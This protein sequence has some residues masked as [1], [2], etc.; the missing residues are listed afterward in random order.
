MK[1]PK[2]FALLYCMLL[3]TASISLAQEHGYV[4]NI[5][6]GIVFID[7]K[8]GQVKTGD[9]LK[10]MRSGG[11][12]VHPVTG[13]T[14]Q[15]RDELVANIHLT[16]V[17]D[18]YSA[19][20]V[21]P[22]EAI[23]LIKTGMKV[24]P[25]A[26]DEA[27]KALIKKSVV[28]PPFLIVGG[29]VGELGAYMSDLMT[30]ELFGLDRF[31]I[32]DRQTYDIQQFEKELLEARTQV[33][34]PV[35]EGVDYL[36]T[37]SAYPPDVV[38]KATG[39]PLKGIVSAAGG[40]LAGVAA[41]NLVPDLK[42]KELEAVVK[43]TLKVIDVRTGEVLFICS[44]M[45]KAEGKTQV[46]LES[47]VIGGAVLN[48]GATD[49][50]NTLTGQASQEA[51]KNASQYIADFFEGKITE[52]NFQGN[53]VELKRHKKGKNPEIRIMDIRRE[54]EGPVAII[55]GGSDD[56]IRSGNH[57]LMTMPNV[58]TSSL[59]G[60]Q[61][62][63]GIQKA[64]RIRPGLVDFD[65]AS[66]P[67]IL[68]PKFADRD[69]DL[70]KEGRL[71]PYKP[72]RAVF[73][74]NVY[75]IWGDVLMDL[76]TGLEYFPNLPGWKKVNHKVWIGVRGQYGF[77]AFLEPDGDYYYR[78]HAGAELLLGMNPFRKSF[79]ANGFDPYMGIKYKMFKVKRADSG[80]AFFLGLNVAGFFTEM[81]LTY[82]LHADMAA[83]SDPNFPT[84]R[85]EFGFSG[86]GMHI[87]Y[88]HIINRLAI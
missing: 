35:N 47:S 14:I 23:I 88:R 45:A 10:V 11:T 7:L 73:G 52:K 65:A 26:P 83:I 53:V 48:G 12:M 82:G 72:F 19:G 9:V 21:Y 66:G 34:L 17:H 5:D 62:V 50:R 77:H 22:K 32:M 79:H 44:E 20:D 46:S 56:G 68:L 55:R 76:D 42:I 81:V 13:E 71:M 30:E 70:V 49:F 18:D 39:V 24:F 51:L 3:G 41:R 86:L 69:A 60:K 28:I 61:K 78:P 85:V 36:V 59:T 74:M 87:G 63:A 75:G 8:A 54:P 80:P 67:V 64:G 57:Y 6:E 4:I 58:V 25:M 37:G 27:G 16:E 33:R 29:K 43:F 38:E 84:D 31:R 1:T 40:G 2:F 15:R